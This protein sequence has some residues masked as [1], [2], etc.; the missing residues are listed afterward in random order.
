MKFLEFLTAFW[1]EIEPVFELFVYLG[2]AK[3]LS[4]LFGITFLQGVAVVY[5]YFIL[6]LSRIVAELMRNRIR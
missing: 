6:S 4:F 2:I 5:V 3:L 1:K